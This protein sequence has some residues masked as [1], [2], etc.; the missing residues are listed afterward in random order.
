VPGFLAADEGHALLAWLLAGADWQ[1][2][3]I[4]LF[5]RARRVPRLVAWYGDAGLCYRYAGASHPARGWP[6]RLAAV[7]DRLND[8]TGERFNFVL[9]NR[10]R[11]GDDG[12]GWHRDDE[13]MSSRCVASISL[14]AARRFLIRPRPGAPSER[15]TL[16]HGSVLLM[17]RFLPHALP[18]TRRS[19]GERVNLSFRSL[20]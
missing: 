3:E 9:L 11:N 17:D 5:G 7:R 2:E 19:V 12:M 4:R 18:K 1:S 20:P 13:A 16:A 15:L 14:G 8:R 10:Y 6:A